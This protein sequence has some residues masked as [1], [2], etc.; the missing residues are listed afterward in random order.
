MAVGVD[1]L[2]DLP[3]PR[4][5]PRTL[6]G[7]ALAAATALLVLFVTRPSATVPVLVAGAD[8]PAGTRL[9]D[10]DVA[11]REVENADGLVAGDELGE[12]EDWI[13]AAPIAAGEPL[14]PSQL[15]P[16]VALDAPDVIAVELDAAN[17]VLGRLSGGDRVDIY[18]TTSEPGSPVR[19]TLIADA[20]YVLEARVEES[21]A[22]PDRVELLLAVD[23]VT[24][25]A[26]TNAI[27][28]GEVDLV[29]V[30]K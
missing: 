14:L 3:L 28:R 7:M 6:L 10:L 21:N 30:G 2:R 13:L 5:A 19:T 16:S 12:L 24:A 15:R 1:N 18:A 17:A 25:Q 27:H 4:V 9:A 11:V 20:L 29:R 22:G 8:L 26:I 23:E